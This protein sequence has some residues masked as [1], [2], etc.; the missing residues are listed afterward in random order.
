M[1]NKPRPK[2][3]RDDRSPGFQSQILFTGERLEEL[4]AICGRSEN[5]DVS[6]LGDI[7]ND[8]DS[9]LQIVKYIHETD[10][11][12][13]ERRKDLQG[14]AKAARGLVSRIEEAD[15]NTR[16]AIYSTYPGTRVIHEQD[17][18]D[19]AMDA[20]EQDDAMDGGKLF[21]QDVEH[22]KRLSYAIE[23]ALALTKGIGGRPGLG[24]LHTTCRDLAE[25]YERF[26]GKRFTFDWPAGPEGA[27]KF[28]TEGTRF[29]AT[30]ALVILPDATIA[31]LTTTM[32]KIATSRT[33][34]LQKPPQKNG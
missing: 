33:E 23:N 18:A 5:D 16:Q 2:P 19:D 14:L 9:V 17:D 3:R 25:R 12:V 21:S 22:L 15:L 1:A 10:V 32:R 7:L 29:V 4:A 30:A 20:D 27:A 34:H 13:S 28:I 11:P 26:S 6:E 8:E 24:D 31:N